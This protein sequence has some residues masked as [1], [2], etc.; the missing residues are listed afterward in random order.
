MAGSVL[1]RLWIVVLAVVIS[2]CATKDQSRVTD[3]VTAPLNDLN[4]VHADIPTVLADAQNQ[5]YGMPK[6]LTCPAL[7]T[8]VQALDAALGADLDTP[9]SEANPGLIE[10]GATAAKDAAVGAVRRTTEGAIPFR[11]W[12]RKLS[13]AE[14]YSKKVSAAIA[15]GTVRR[16][17]LKGIKVSKDCS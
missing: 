11:S 14:R 15:A 10:R 3:A 13:G 1:N 4:L 7:T 16:A 5:P 9:V 12:V 2:S 8:D 17:F 6:N